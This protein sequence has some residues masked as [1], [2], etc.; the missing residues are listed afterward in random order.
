MLLVIGAAQSVTRKADVKL[1]T[2]A[3]AVALRKGQVK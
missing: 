1:L 3:G 2:L